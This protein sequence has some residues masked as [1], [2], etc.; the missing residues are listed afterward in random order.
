MLPGSLKAVLGVHLQSVRRLH[1]HD[2]SAG[3]GSVELP[4]ALA[5]KY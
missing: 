1:D 2:L 3:G 4:G 5:A